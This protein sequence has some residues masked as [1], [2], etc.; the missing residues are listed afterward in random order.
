M[1]FGENV[2]LRASGRQCYVKAILSL[3]SRLSSRQ[4]SVQ[5]EGVWHLWQPR[6]RN[7]RLAVLTLF[8]SHVILH[9]RDGDDAALHVRQDGA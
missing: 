5:A 8:D 3:S 4:A 7:G 6:R 1:Y 2:G 9:R